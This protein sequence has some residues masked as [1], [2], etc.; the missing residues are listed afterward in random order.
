LYAQLE[1]L[2]RIQKKRKNIWNRYYANLKPL[3][4]KGELKLPV[5]PYFS[6]NNAHMFYICL[7]SMEQR[8]ALIDFF[9]NNGI[10]AVFHYVSLNKSAYY[11]S[12]FDKVDLVNSDYYS[13]CLLR[14]PFY[15]ELSDDEID[16][17]TN[18]IELFFNLPN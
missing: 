6:S 13:E 4:T 2:D 8:T 10:H 16:E 11:L 3:E 7:K 15:F 1:N 9:A 5:V 18:C 14:L 17:I 12:Q